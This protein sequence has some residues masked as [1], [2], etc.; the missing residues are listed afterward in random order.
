M[1]ASTNSEGSVVDSFLPVNI[2]VAANDVKK[3]K[4]HAFTNRIDLGVLRRDRFVLDAIAAE[5]FSKL[6]TCKFC[7]LIVNNLS[8]SW[9]T[10]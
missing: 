1:V 10:T 9:I 4:M 8:R 7:S 5:N 2:F 3:L 6:C